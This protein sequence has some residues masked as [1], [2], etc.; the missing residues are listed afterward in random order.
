[1]AGIRQIAYMAFSVLNHILTLVVFVVFLL[2][3]QGELPAAWH[4]GP[5]LAWG[6]ALAINLGIMVLWSLQHTGMAAPAFKAW[7]RP[8]VPLALERSLYCA[9]T[10]A[11]LLLVIFCWVPMPAVVFRVENAVLAGGI[12][13][14]FWTVW[15][16]F[17]LSLVLDSYWEFFGLK[18]AYCFMTGFPFVMSSFKTR[19]LHRYVRHPSLSLII[20]GLWLTP[21]MTLDRLLL[22]GAM[23]LYTVLGA[24]SVD[25]KFLGYYGAA[26]AQRQ[27]EVPLLVPRLFCRH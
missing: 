10:S 26:Y 4:P 18:Q 6:W 7:S 2:Y 16:L 1:M 19:H 5:E 13:V 23:T 8:L 20:I 24:Y 17:F 22:S 25:R 9:L 15:G 12:R 14:A 27:R 21:Q 11:A 3:L